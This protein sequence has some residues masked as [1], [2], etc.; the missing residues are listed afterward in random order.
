MS[1]NHVGGYYGTTRRN[2][3]ISECGKY[4]YWLGRFWDDN[5]APLPFVM[6]NPSTADALKD[7]ATI[8]KCIGFARKFGYGGIEV[9]NLFAYRATKPKDLRDAGWP[10]GMSND[11]AIHETAIRA[12]NA[13]APVVCAWGANARPHRQYAGSILLALASLG[14]RVVALRQLNDGTPEHPLML[15]YSCELIPLVPTL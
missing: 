13:G 8:R 2:A 6:L 4:R 10:K 14:C 5:K 7:D 15:P 9:V 3:T 1:A 11:H 12:I